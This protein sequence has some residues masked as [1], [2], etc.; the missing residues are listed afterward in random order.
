MI[1]GGPGSYMREWTGVRPQVLIGKPGSGWQKARNNLRSIQAKPPTACLHIR[2]LEKSPAIT[3][4]RPT[5]D[6]FS[7]VCTR[8]DPHL[9]LTAQQGSCRDMTRAKI[10]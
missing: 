4:C 9:K 5:K 2:P 3:L 1:Q 8:T 7:I 6:F 10:A